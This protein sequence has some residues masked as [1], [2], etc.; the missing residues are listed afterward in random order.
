LNSYTIVPARPEHLSALADIE[1]EASKIFPSDLLP[2]GLSGQTVSP[3]AL[4]D[5]LTDGLL[6]VIV[7]SDGSPVGFIL[8]S[9]HDGMMFIKEMDVHPHHQQQGLG[10]ALIR[11]AL[12]AA[13]QRGFTRAAL[14]T[15]SSL[16]WN[17]PFYRKLGFTTLEY[18]NTPEVIRTILNNECEAG[19]K[20]RV[21]MI[22]DLQ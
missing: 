13:R 6:W 3:E 21:A 8:L 7:E 4:H 16:P 18:G 14:T 10:S 17:A 20:D 19:L 22:K 1:L 11:T 9:V 5:G 2:A 15:F 12:S